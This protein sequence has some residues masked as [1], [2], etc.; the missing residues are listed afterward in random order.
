MKRTYMV[1]YE[2]MAEDNWG[3]WCPDIGGAVGAGNSLPQARLSLRAGMD[4]MLEDLTERGL[5]APPAISKSIDF[6][7]FDPNPADSHYE[8]EWMTIDLP[9]IASTPSGNQQATAA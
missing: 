2:R 6:S 8:V 5:P 9:E 3:A 7:E 4:I 1:V